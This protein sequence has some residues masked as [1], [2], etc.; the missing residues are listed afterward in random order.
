MTNLQQKNDYSEFEYQWVILI[1]CNNLLPRQDMLNILKHFNM[2]FFGDD[3][4]NK[5]SLE[6]IGNVIVSDTDRDDLFPYLPE[7]LQTHYPA[8]FSYEE[9]NKIY[10][11]LLNINN[12]IDITKIWLA[13]AE[14]SPYKDYVKDLLKNLENS[15]Q[16][17]KINDFMSFEEK[18][19]PGST[20][21]SMT[22]EIIL[23]LYKL[24][25]KSYTK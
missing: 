2:R 20:F 18:T 1:L 11:A 23:S 21:W 14:N 25:M 24:A 22:I 9:V 16:Q 3:W 6:E 19:H 8:L 5:T 13:I 15:Y 4:E 17:G 7:Y 12:E 10:N